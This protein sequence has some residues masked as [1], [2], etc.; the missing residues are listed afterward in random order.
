MFIYALAGAA[1]V[2]KNVK[3][4]IKYETTPD[5]G[6]NKNVSRCCSCLCFSWTTEQ[7]QEG[8]QMLKVVSMDLRNVRAEMIQWVDQWWASRVLNPL[9]SNCNKI[10]NDTILEGTTNYIWILFWVQTRGS[11]KSS[12]FMV[13]NSMFCCYLITIF[14]YIFV[15]VMVVMKQK[16]IKSWTLL[17]KYLLSML[18]YKWS[19]LWG[20]RASSTLNACFSTKNYAWWKLLDSQ[21]SD[22]ILRTR[23]YW[24]YK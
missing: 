6:N 13:W 17:Q 9:K 22:L 4:Y 8:R 14:S 19:I 7:A 20:I 1:A 12:M 24:I 11:N 5:I 3:K 2:N 15:V 16:R 18:K 23:G 10:P 21:I